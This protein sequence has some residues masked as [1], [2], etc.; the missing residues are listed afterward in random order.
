MHILVPVAGKYTKIEVKIPVEGI[1]TSSSFGLCPT[2]RRFLLVQSGLR[3]ET[4]DDELT[5]ILF[6]LRD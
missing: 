1:G 6:V 3:F 2:S 4:K 5:A